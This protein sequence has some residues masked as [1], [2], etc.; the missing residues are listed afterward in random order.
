[1]RKSHVG[2]YAAFVITGFVNGT[3]IQSFQLQINW[4]PSTNEVKE[5]TRSAN[6]KKDGKFIKLGAVATLRYYER[7]EILIV[8]VTFYG[9]L[10]TPRLRALLHLVHAHKK[11]MDYSKLGSRGRT[12]KFP[13]LRSCDES[14]MSF[15]NRSGESQ[16]QRQ[17]KTRH[18]PITILYPQ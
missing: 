6:M 4:I 14:L 5:Q 9:N 7:I 1:V 2:F 3:E 11:N 18:S 17:R 13:A 12:S 15:R 16:C 10:A 8:P